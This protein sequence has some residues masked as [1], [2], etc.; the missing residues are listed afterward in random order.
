MKN[1]MNTDQS[2]K[3]A[4][5]PEYWMSLEQFQ[6]D[7]EFAKRAENEFLASP[8]ASSQDGFARR[9]FL[10]LMGASIALASAGCIRRPVQHIIPY[11]QAPKEVT[12]GIPNLYASTWYDGVEGYGVIAKT[13]EGRP[14]KLEGNPSHPMNLGSLTARGQAAVLSLYDPDRLKGP[15]RNLQNAERTN[16]ETIS[17]T[18][19][20]LD[21]AVVEELR[22][23]SVAVLSSTRPSPSERAAIGDFLKAYQGRWVQYDSLPADDVAEAQRRSYGR[24]VVPR[25]RIDRADLIVSIDADFLGTYLSP[26]EF[27]KQWAK[28]RKPG[29]DMNRLVMFEANM[30]LTGMNADD[31]FRIKPSQ[32]LDA[33]MALMSEV[34]KAS[35]GGFSLPAAAQDYVRQ[36]GDLAARLGLPMEDLKKVAQQL[37][38][39]RG[40]SL[41]IAGGLTAR[42]EQSVDLQIAVNMLNSALG[43]DG[44]TIDHDGSPYETRQGSAAQLA[45][46]ID[47]MKSGRVRSL[48]IHDLNP[49]YVLPADSGFME[50]IGKVQF[51][52]YTGNRND[53]T[54]KV[55]NFV[56]P[57]GTTLES[58]GD[59]ELQTGLVSIQQPTI[60]PLHDT[61]SFGE[62]LLAW[63][64]TQGGAPARMKS[65]ET[66]YDFVRSV[67]RSDVFPKAGA[68]K[69]FDDFWH[70]VLQTGV[71]DMGGRRDRDGSARS[72]A[73]GAFTAKPRAAAAGY[74]LALYSTVQLADGQYANVAWLQELPDPVTKIVWD[75]YLMISPAAAR[76]EALS[77]GDMVQLKVGQKTV[78]VPVHI[79]PGLHDEVLALAVGYGRPDPGKVARGVGVNAYDLVSFN[80]GRPVFSG[81][82]ASIRKTGQKYRLVS[83]QDHHVMEGRQIVVET[84]NTAWE[85]NSSAGIHR[86]AVFS[87]WPQHQYTKRR[88]G[89]A[90]DLSTCTGCSACVVACQSENNVPVVGKKYVMEG[91]EM[92]WLR[93]DRYYKGSPDSPESVFMPMLCQHCENAPCETV[94]PVL[95]TVHNDEGL[96]DMV[97]NRCVG[98]RYC[99]NNCPYKVRRFNWFN[100]SK[101]ES[102]LEMALNPEVTVRTRGV[103][104]KCTF[105]VQRIRHV[106]GITKSHKGAH[107]AVKDGEIKTACQETCPADA[108]IFGDLNDKES[109]VRRFF[110]DGRAY[111]VLEEVNT[112]PRIRY[113]TR[114]RNAERAVVDGH[115]HGDAHG[116]HGHGM[117][118]QP[119]SQQG[120]RV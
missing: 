118:K 50:A 2:L 51:V 17:S 79:Q 84:T 57:A 102:P 99:A 43:N 39:A 3:N 25:Y 89:M 58:W 54:G 97:Y 113:L 7:P 55:A 67:W 30:S 36:M 119:E 111:S 105:C 23:G 87:I 10:K 28:R 83:T 94:C 49:A 76:K 15:V 61:R 59:Y 85:K 88:W 52:V 46:L 16:R 44:R 77:E 35:G 86:H 115:G 32:Q 73:A 6:G 56:V 18:W 109:A 120:E 22:Q 33:V 38:A 117:Q 66:W 100:Y 19:E 98:T 37:W 47:D 95:A 78:N 93:I 40:K 114:V 74:E 64:K 70:G 14:I 26:A 21:Q 63:G 12:P 4:A 101:R 75:N 5:G 92:H 103:M 80:G 110:E 53:E 107:E 60:R 96:N 90:I 45:T 81:M 41:V 71:V 104:E 42:T 8:F 108:I 9:D 13:L 24:A 20:T 68:G 1:E 82:A 72:V 11:A 69:S 34:A 106:V 65:S 91:R 27:M 48:I 116:D 31:R 112:Q 62:S 29:K